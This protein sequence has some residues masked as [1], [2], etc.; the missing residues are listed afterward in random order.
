M[1]Y[2]QQHVWKGTRC[3]KKKEASGVLQVV[4]YNTGTMCSTTLEIL[5]NLWRG[6]VKPLVQIYRQNKNRGLEHGPW[7]STTVSLYRRYQ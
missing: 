6:N 4:V 2:N 7:D 1:Q 3:W 5:E